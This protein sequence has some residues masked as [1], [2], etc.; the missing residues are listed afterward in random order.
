MAE[1]ARCRNQNPRPVGTT[2]VKL[3]KMYRKAERIDGR[4][5]MTGHGSAPALGSFTSCRRK[6]ILYTTRTNN[7]ELKFQFAQNLGSNYTKSDLQKPQRHSVIQDSDG[8]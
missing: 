6:L 7:R 1:E 5:E 2:H 8:L 3:Y 4:K